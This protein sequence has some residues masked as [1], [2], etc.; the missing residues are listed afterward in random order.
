VFSNLPF[1]LCH[2][3][4]LPPTESRQPTGSQVEGYNVIVGF[5]GDLSVME[6]LKK[7]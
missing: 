5:A 6:E 7:R 2:P 1:T 4:A 3:E